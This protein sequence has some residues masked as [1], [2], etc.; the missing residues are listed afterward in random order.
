MPIAVWSSR[1]ETGI[2]TIDTQHRALFDALNQLTEAFRT[3]T[4][5]EHVKAGLNALLAYALEH[6]QTEEA[7]M[8]ERAYPGLAAHLAEHERLV[9]KAQQLEEQFR[10]GKAVTMEVTIFLADLL[11][12]HIDEYDLAMVRFLT[13]QPP[14]VT[15]QRL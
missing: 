6:F 14:T 4:S 7:Y 2:D 8:R 9:G 3:G 11:A 13:V 5:E 10:G 12:Q 1:Y 15:I